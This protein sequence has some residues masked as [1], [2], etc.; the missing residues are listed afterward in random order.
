LQETVFKCIY[1]KK[2]TFGE[3]GSYVGA[4]GSPPERRTKSGG[5]VNLK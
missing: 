4:R 3:G 2:E 5:M 1:S